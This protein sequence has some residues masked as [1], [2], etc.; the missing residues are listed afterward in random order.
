LLSNVISKTTLA[1][2]V[3]LS[4]QD[5]DFTSPA[6]LEIILR[7]L[8][9]QYM[10]QSDDVAA[11][12][13]VAGASASGSTWTVTAGDPSSLIAAIYDAATDVLAATNFL[14]DHIFV[15]PATWKSLGSQLD[16]DNRPVFPY[17][18][19]AGLMGVNGMGTANVTQMNTFNPLGL[20]LVVD[21]NFAAGTMVVARASAIEFFEQIRGIMTRDEVS[22][23]GKVFSYHG[24]VSTFIADA[25]Q[26]K[27]IIIA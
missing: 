12:A 1:G 21:R 3:T 14:P 11:D 18:G 8:A 9:G 16:A 2:Q 26:V 20:N 17:T 15:D 19:A 10:L 24:Y 27:S 23:L 5:V 22:T 25:D 13:I 6:A 7:D 4:V